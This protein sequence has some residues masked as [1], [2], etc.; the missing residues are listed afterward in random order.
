MP[1]SEGRVL[2]ISYDGLAEPLGQSQVVGYLERLASAH[3]I[4]VLSYEKIADL[5]D[6]VQM[7]AVQERLTAAGIQWV[8][9]RYHKRPSLPA[10]AWDIVAGILAGWRLCITQRVRLVHARGYVPSAIALVLQRLC[11]VKFLFDMRG[12][13]P[14]E[15]V[16]AGHWSRR[17]LAYR[18]AKR[19]ECCFFERA[20]AIVS[21][22]DA[23]V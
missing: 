21:L 10:T 7:R 3:Q 5:R 6:R 2:Y 20:D 19:W 12:F 4:T 17:S 14:E 1:A 15:K 18:L 23:G 13:W 11:G 22:T 8:P 16:E 9:L